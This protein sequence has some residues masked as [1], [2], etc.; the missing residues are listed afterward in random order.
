MV[1]LDPVTPEAGLS[2]DVVSVADFRLALADRRSIL[3][4][5]DPLKWNVGAT[6][7]L[8]IAAPQMGQ[9]SGPAA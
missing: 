5:P 7:A 3:A 9:A 6:K 8:R 1:G 2:D 4:Q